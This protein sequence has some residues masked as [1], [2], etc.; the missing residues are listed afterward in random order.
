M[1]KQMFLIWFKQVHFLK[2]FIGIFIFI[3]FN[4]FLNLDGQKAYEGLY[5]VML[6]VTLSLLVVDVIDSKFHAYEKCSMKSMFRIYN[7][8]FVFSILVVS[9]PISVY[10]LFFNP[11]YLI[12][13]L[14]S[15]V[16]ISRIL[17][18]SILISNSKFIGILIVLFIS[19]IWFDAKSPSFL[20]FFTVYLDYSIIGKLII[21]FLVIISDVFTRRIVND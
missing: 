9:L 21:T 17:H 12:L 1:Y 6:P 10:L 4:L 2:F 7:I 19:L 14:P 13:F 20:N 8:K 15:L 3:C 5:E 11:Y 18:N 16:I